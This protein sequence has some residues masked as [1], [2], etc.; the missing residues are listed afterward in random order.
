MRRERLW[1]TSLNLAGITAL[2]FSYG[3]ALDTEKF[4]SLLSTAGVPLA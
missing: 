3:D 1:E 2:R 4:F